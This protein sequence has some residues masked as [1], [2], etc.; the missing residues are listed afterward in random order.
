MNW[1]FRIAFGEASTEPQLGLWAS[2]CLRVAALQHCQ[3][4]PSL[5]ALFHFLLLAVVRASELETTV[6]VGESSFSRAHS[7][8]R[9][10]WVPYQC[11]AKQSILFSL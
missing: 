5:V 1:R 9:D 7:E 6:L 3:I 4:E 11:I 8:E 10:R 2:H